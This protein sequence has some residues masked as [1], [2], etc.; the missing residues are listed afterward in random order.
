MI[1]GIFGTWRAIED[2]PVYRLSLDY[3]RTLGTAGCR[4]LT[5]GYSG[6]MEAACRGAVDSGG[7]T[8]GV[9][10][11]ELDRLLPVNRWVTKE[12]KACDL[13]DRLATCF[14]HVDA[15]L[16][17]PGRSGTMTELSL[18]LELR[19]KGALLH[20][21]LLSCS[22]WDDLLSVRAA[23][24]LKLPHPQGRAREPL[25]LHCSGPER[26]LTQLGVGQ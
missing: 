18:A 26:I 6:V 15:A 25:Y 8:I 13:Q 24:N 17:L 10:C 16:F 4:V 7:E 20:P 14:R 19:E 23:I 1:V 21:V 22:F 2:D 3:G 5:G 9:T 11:P 12:I